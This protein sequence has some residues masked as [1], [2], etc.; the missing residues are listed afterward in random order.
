MRSARFNDLLA[1]TAVAFALA[2]A[3]Y[4]GSAFAATDATPAATASVPDGSATPSAVKEGTAPAATPTAESQPKPEPAAA[5]AP[6]TT[7]AAAKPAATATQPETIQPAAA[8]PAPTVPAAAASAPA[9]PAGTAAATPATPPSAEAAL[10]DRIRDQFET[11]KFDRILGGKK[12]RAAVEAFYA[13]R[14]FAPLWVTDGAMNARAKA[15]A[16]YLAGV[17]ADGLEPADYPVPDFKA[18]TEALAESEMRLTD[19]VLTYARH[20]EGGRVHYS[21]VSSDILYTLARPEPAQVL[22][23]LAE[24]KDTA[25][26]LDSFEPPHAAYKA[27]KAKLAE[28]RAKIET[29]EKEDVVRVPEGKLLRLGMEDDRVP[30]LRK[31]LKVA[32]DP[33]SR[34]YDQTVVDAVKTFQHEAG[35]TADGLLGANTLRHINGG[36]ARTRANV[37]D[38]IIANMER[39]R[40]VPRDLGR[41]HV[42]VNIPDYT[43]RVI[44]DGKQI[45][46]TNIVVGK[47]AMPT[48]LISAEMKYITVNP[49]WNVP[50]SIIQNEYLPA[51][52]QDP[53]AMERIG[54]KVEQRPDGTIRIY[55]PPGDRNA[56]GR[57]RFNF[58]NKFLVYQHDTPDKQ[59]FAHSKRAYSHGCM[60]V[61]DPLKYGEV[62]LGQVLPNEHYTA[63]RL[64]KMFG[65][66]EINISFPHPIPVH[67]TYQ[68]AFVDDAGNLQLRDDVYGRDAR[69]LAI[70]KG[71]ERRVADIAIERPRGSSTAPV[72][73]P[74]GTFGGSQPAGGFF[75]GPSFFERLFG[76]GFSEQQQ[77]APRPR[78]GMRQSAR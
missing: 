48:P 2:L 46:K 12:E 55:Q 47:P 8:Q 21:R 72:K 24:A 37:V 58:P 7:P 32:Q 36:T 5:A 59:L 56:L 74:P 76:G 62:L 29:K 69:L 68:T 25:A 50:P 77:P 39:W 75:S 71:S 57:I 9:Q 42:T 4:A 67:L 53:Q 66:S 40:W 18:G 49:T 64:H 35:L 3:P 6:A 45:W 44:R 10:A 78:N 30:L 63:E 23:K 27:L 51:L 11:G 14:Q 28:A 70:M 1:G 61:Q 43:L 16:A 20:A 13:A 54:L 33:D 17:A 73:M 26:A 38:T 52:Q 15:V 34:R 41:L 65:G 19:T 60:R 22:T 31:R